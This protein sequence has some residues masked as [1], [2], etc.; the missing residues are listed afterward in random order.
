MLFE[1]ATGDFLFDPKGGP[2]FGKEDDHLAQMIEALGKMPKAFALSGSDSM[3]YFNRR[4]QLYNVRHLKYWPVK[5]ILMEKYSFNEEEAKA[6]SDFLKPMLVYQPEFR[7]S[8]ASCMMHSWLEMPSNYNTKMSEGEYAAL[9]D[10]LERQ[11]TSRKI[12]EMRG[13]K[14]SS[15]E[16][17]VE[18]SAW[19]G[20]REDNSSFESSDMDEAS[21]AKQEFEEVTEYH[22]RMQQIAGM[23]LKLND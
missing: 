14:S 7:A 22:E 23:C 6:F 12:A 11:Q 9:M 19:E 1:L 21:E 17:P 20:D 18:G 5:D 2:D 4:G 8:A 16:S 3:K 13:E 10:K 15:P